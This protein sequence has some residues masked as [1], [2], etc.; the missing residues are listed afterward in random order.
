MKP[1]PTATVRSATRR[2]ACPGG[3]KRNEAKSSCS[4]VMAATPVHLRVVGRSVDLDKRKWAEWL[5]SCLLWRDQGWHGK[6]G[7]AKA[8]GRPPWH[9][10]RV[11]KAVTP[12]QALIIKHLNRNKTRNKTSHGPSLY[13]RLLI[14]A[15]PSGWAASDGGFCRRPADGGGREERAPQEAA[16][17]RCFR[18]YFTNKP[19]MHRIAGG[20]WNGASAFL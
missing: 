5:R 7:R 18:F 11:E 3:P 8:A 12:S 17:G 4:A 6:A 20:G 2:V 13:L 1:T 19:E 16:H 9:T 14:C 15:S 10:L